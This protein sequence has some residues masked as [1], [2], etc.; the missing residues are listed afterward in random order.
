M[1]LTQ[2]SKFYKQAVKQIKTPWQGKPLLGIFPSRVAK[3]VVNQFH[4][5][6]WQRN[7]SLKV[8]T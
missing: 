4:A 5:F 3:A 7:T 8:E 1:P 2:A 6:Q